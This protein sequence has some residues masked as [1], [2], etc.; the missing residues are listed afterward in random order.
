MFL[1]KTIYFLTSFFIYMLA[2]VI[3]CGYSVTTVSST[4][5]GQLSCMLT[6]E[7][8]KHILHHVLSI[9]LSCI[10]TWP[11]NSSYRPAQSLCC[12]HIISYTHGP[13]AAHIVQLKA[14]AVITSSHIHMAH[15]QLISSSSKPLLSSHHLIYTWPTSSSYRPAQSLCCHHIISYTHGPQAA[16]IVQLKASAVIISSHIHM[17]HKSTHKATYSTF[18]SV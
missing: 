2:H 4:V 12:H 7:L 8:T 3:S 5:E 14:S 11:T 6:A 1:L 17:A 13:Q 16:H 9:L 15:K 18:V 10:Y